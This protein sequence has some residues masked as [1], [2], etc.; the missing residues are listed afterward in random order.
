MINTE[1]MILEISDFCK[2]EL[3]NSDFFTCIYG[4]FAT[5]D[6]GSTSDLDILFA[7]DIYTESQF[8]LIRD[9]VLKLRTK[10]S[11]TIDE[12]IPYKNK[13]LLSY[14]D[15]L[16]SSQ[17][18]CFNTETDG[19]YKIS[20]IQD[21]YEYLSSK[22]ARDRLLLNIFTTPNIFI[23]GNR[24]KYD[25]FKLLMEKSLF[26]LIYGLL[27]NDKNITKEDLY[28][29]LVFDESGK[30]GRSYLGYKTERKLVQAHI[31]SLIEK[32]YQDYLNG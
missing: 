27:K 19:L 13:L 24:V 3:A 30:K 14:S 31:L 20:P 21:S 5:G 23:T 16:H 18:T 17:I 28:N 9:F 29:K 10:Y 25:Q 2:K 32:Y 11:L 6:N 22:E 15:I 26:K 12:E 8:N 7:T 4:S 1:F